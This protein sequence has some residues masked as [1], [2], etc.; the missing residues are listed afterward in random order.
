MG[1][2]YRLNPKTDLV[3]LCS[4]CHSMVHTE[5]PPITPEKLKQIVTESRM[6]ELHDTQTNI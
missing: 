5:S 1:E 4:N 6:K 3:P 2:E